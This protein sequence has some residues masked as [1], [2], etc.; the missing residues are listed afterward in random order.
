[1]YGT[2]HSVEKPFV[3][4]SIACFVQRYSRLLRDVVVKNHSKTGSFW[5]PSFRETSNSGRAFSTLV[6][7]RIYGKVWLTRV[8]YLRGSKLAMTVTVGQKLRLTTCTSSSLYAKVHQILGEI[9]NPNC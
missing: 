9:E 8:R 2:F 3:L 5:V 6:H 1:M 4:L 7:S